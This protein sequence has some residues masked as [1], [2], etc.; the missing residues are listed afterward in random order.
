VMEPAGKGAARERF[1]R[2]GVRP[3]H[4]CLPRKKL[5]WR[6]V[7]RQ[8]PAHHNRTFTTESFPTPA[9]SVDKEPCVAPR[10]F[11]ARFERPFL[12]ANAFSRTTPAARILQ[13]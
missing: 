2:Y 12:Q 8:R 13:P 11:A 1:V 9:L 6:G 10:R 7:D 5:G 4:Y 3:I